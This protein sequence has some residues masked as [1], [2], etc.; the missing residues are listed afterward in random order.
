VVPGATRPHLTG[1]A[2]G[3]AQHTRP[4]LRE[5][6]PP[7]GS[8]MTDSRPERAPAAIDLE[9][10]ASYASYAPGAPDAPYAPYA[11]HAAAGTEPAATAG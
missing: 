7:E 10:H 3:T 4:H 8:D 5:P 1:A 11:S 2:P 9:R 6:D